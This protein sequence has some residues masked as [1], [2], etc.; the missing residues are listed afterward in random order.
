MIVQLPELYSARHHRLRKILCRRRDRFECGAGREYLF[1]ISSSIHTFDTI[2][3]LTPEISV[4]SARNSTLR[5]HSM[6]KKE[7]TACDE[8]MKAKGMNTKRA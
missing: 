2:S 4:I 6:G 8:L 3:Q 7:K 1:H 5:F